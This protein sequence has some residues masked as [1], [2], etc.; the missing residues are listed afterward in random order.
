[1]LVHNS[2][3]QQRVAG[4]KDSWNARVSVGGMNDHNP[5]H[6]QIYYK[7]DKLASVTGEGEFL[8]AS[9]GK[10][11]GGYAFVKK[12]LPAIA[13]GIRVWWESLKE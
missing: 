9:F 10:L 11:K 13:E 4:N 6:A 5:P 12:N 3:K 8:N 7:N 2:C 1:M